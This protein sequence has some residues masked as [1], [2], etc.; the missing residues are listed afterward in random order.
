MKSKVS[1]NLCRGFFECVFQRTAFT[2]IRVMIAGAILIAM[3]NPSA[4]EGQITV[5]SFGGSGL[6]NATI[7][8]NQ[9][10]C[11]L[12]SGNGS[13]SYYSAY[14]DST[15]TVSYMVNGVES[16]STGVE[17]DTGQSFDPTG[18]FVGVISL[19][20]APSESLGVYYPTGTINDSSL[21]TAWS[22]IMRGLK[23]PCSPQP[24]RSARLYVAR[25]FR[26][27]RFQSSSQL[28]K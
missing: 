2:T 8:L 19:D 28:Q 22:H 10:A 16:N 14:F 23:S 7:T 25:E 21:S 24:C 6:S 20:W 4:S 13:N 9:S 1:I 11:T 18:Q 15:A 27:G 5:I 26:N 3:L 12:I 17:I